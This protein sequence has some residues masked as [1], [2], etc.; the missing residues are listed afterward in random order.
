MMTGH[1]PAYF[2]AGIWNCTYIWPIVIWWGTLAAA[3]PPGPP[4]G[5]ACSVTFGTPPM[6]KLPWSS[7][8]SGP[9]R[10]LFEP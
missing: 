10:N 8:V 1:P 2:R 9:V 7:I 5:A 6:K 4:A 3:A